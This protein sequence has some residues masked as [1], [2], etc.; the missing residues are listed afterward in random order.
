MF[1]NIFNGTIECKVH[2]GCVRIHDD[3]VKWSITIFK[4]CCITVNFQPLGEGGAL[5]SS[6]PCYNEWVFYYWGYIIGYTLQV[7]YSHIIKPWAVLA[8]LVKYHVVNHHISADHHVDLS[9]T[10]FTNCLLFHL[11]G[12]DSFILVAGE[13]QTRYQ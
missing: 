13:Q 4:Q 7:L 12:G 2:F 3:K 6:Q 1:F 10:A 9:W 11:G 8:F 5:F